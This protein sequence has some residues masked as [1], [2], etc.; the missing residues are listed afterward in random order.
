M[1]LLFACIASLAAIASC[2]PASM[3]ET[4]SATGDARPRPDA[5]EPTFDAPSFD[6]TEP[7]DGAQPTSCADWCTLRL[8]ECGDPPPLAR[9]LCAA[10]CT[11][12]TMPAA[13]VSCLR[14]MGCVE[15]RAAL[16]RNAEICGLEPAGDSGVR[17]DTGVPVDTGVDARSDTGTD[18]RTDTGTD[19]RSDTGVDARTDSGVDARSDTGVDARSD[20]GVDARTD[21]GVDARTSGG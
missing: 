15:I 10:R 3:T 16:S 12:A 8:S 9:E 2:A 7:P 11:M 4:D 21:T 20:T 13:A 6:A 17:M 1:R 5:I 14:S 18:A 19:A